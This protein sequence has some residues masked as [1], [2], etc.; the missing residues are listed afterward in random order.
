MTDEDVLELLILA[1]FNSLFE[2]SSVERIILVLS[3]TS[4]SAAPEQVVEEAPEDCREAN[5]LEVLD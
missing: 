5:V 1:L 4:A 3:M 2:D